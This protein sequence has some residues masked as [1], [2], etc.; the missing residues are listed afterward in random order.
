MAI[1]NLGSALLASALV[2][3]TAS[4]VGAQ[5]SG[6]RPGFPCAKAS[7]PPERLICGDPGPARLDRIM[8]D[9][10]AQTRSLLLNA[11]Q[12][13][14]AMRASARGWRAATG[15]A[16]SGACAGPFR[17]PPPRADGSSGG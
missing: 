16:T 3:A 5:A 10:F 8:A 11:A 1:R 2:A 15:A 13:A 4:P 7:K 14:E 9:L 12:T 17:S 6:A